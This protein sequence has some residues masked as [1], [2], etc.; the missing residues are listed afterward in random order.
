MSFIDLK[1]F[2]WL[3]VFVLFLTKA[4]FLPINLFQS[5]SK[6]GRQQLFGRMLVKHFYPHDALL[7]WYM[8]WRCV[9][10]SVTIWYCIEMA[11]QIK[12][13][14]GVEAALTYPALL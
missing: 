11:E 2:V 5:Y 10:P 4:Y 12:V 1:I 14:F 3:E 7:Q 6:S 13:V 8:L 9:C